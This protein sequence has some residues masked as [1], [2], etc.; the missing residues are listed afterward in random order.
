[1]KI[2]VIGQCYVGLTISIGALSAGHH[3]IGVDYSK[4]LINSLLAG[5]S[6]IEGISDNQIAS[7]ISIGKYL[8]T[9][10]YADI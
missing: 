7:G 1:M 3:V 10:K 6:H 2:A 9:N 4:D 5:K 8:P